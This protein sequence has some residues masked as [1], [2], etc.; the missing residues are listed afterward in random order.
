MGF[1]LTFSTFSTGLEEIDLCLLAVINL[2]VIALV[3]MRL[4]V[5]NLIRVPGMCKKSLCNVYVPR[6]SQD[7]LVCM[8][9]VHRHSRLILLS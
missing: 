5:I 9:M 8:F 1:W 6:P 4:A 2:S 3:T 7:N